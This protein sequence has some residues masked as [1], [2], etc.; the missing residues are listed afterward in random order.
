MWTS[1]SI[2]VTVAAIGLTAL[3]AVWVYGAQNVHKSVLTSSINSNEK[4]LQD[5]QIDKYLTIQNQLATLSGLHGQK[6][7]FSRLLD[8]LPSLNPGGLTISDLT[9]DAE[10]STIDFQGD[11]PTYK[12]LTTFKDTLVNAT[13]SYQAP[14]GDTPTTGPLFSN[15][16]VITSSLADKEKGTGKIV[17][18]EIKANYEPNAFIYGNQNVKV[19][20]PDKD[21]TNS[22]VNAPVFS[23]EQAKQNGG[24]Q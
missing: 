18:F 12:D 6:N 11:V 14:G 16:S 19:Q 4:K 3:V 8:F 17:S 21:T 10:A 24:S 15:V 22:T 20:V 9:V 5:K 23:G 13:V 2:L 7:D 1:V